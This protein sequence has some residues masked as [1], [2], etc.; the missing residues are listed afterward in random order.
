VGPRASLK[1][2]RKSTAHTRIQIQTVQPVASS[3]TYIKKAYRGSRGTA[4]H[5]HQHKMDISP[6]K[7]PRYSLTEGWVC[8]RNCLNDVKKG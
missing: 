6:G 8:P 5:Y 2:K 7:E 1:W 3:Y 4:P